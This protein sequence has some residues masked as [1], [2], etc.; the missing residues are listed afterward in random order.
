MCIQ[1]GKTMSHPN[2]MHWVHPDFYLKTRDEMMALFGELEDA[3]NRPWEIAQRCNV[4]GTP[5]GTQDVDEE[6]KM[7]GEISAADAPSRAQM[8]Q[9]GAAVRLAATASPIDLTLAIAIGRLDPENLGD[10]LRFQ[11]IA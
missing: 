3:V 4:I 10:L 2:R 1:T 8:P 9:P 11:R 6:T 5:L 7:I